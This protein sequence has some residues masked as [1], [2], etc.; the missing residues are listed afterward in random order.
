MKKSIFY[1]LLVNFAI[2]SFSLV[3]AS[4]KMPKGII[5]IE[6]ENTKSNLGEWKLRT[7]NDSNFVKRAGNNKHIEFTAGTI[8]GGPATSPLEYT[9]SVPTTGT[10]RLMIVCNKRLEG[11]S[12]DKCN[13]GWVK[14]AGNFES[15]NE[16]PVA[17]LKKNEKF[18]GGAAN[19]WGWGDL[20]DWQGHIKR[21]ALYNLKSGESYT[22]IMSGRSIRW[23]V[24]KI[25]LFD[26]LKFKMEDAKK[27]ILPSKSMI[28]ENKW[29][30]SVKDFVPAYYDQGN[31]AFAINTIAQPT[32]K[33]AAANQ[34]YKGNP[35]TYTLNF[36]SLLEMDGECSYKVIIDGKQV[37]SF[38]NPRIHGT[39]TKEYTPHLVKVENI[40]LKKGSVIEV[41]FLSNSNKLV[42]E[43]DAFGFARARWQDIELIKD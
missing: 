26:T 2:S 40:K 12:G 42:P 10:Y 17:D 16:I 43:K 22:F 34:I 15:G 1:L 3:Y 8:N 27:I 28:A 6:A 32:N 31:K 39:Q 33:W 23:N 36:R 9:F 35:G 5:V 30:L 4:K 19:G 18:F 11:A 41:Q 20:L 14:M 7:P 21:P 37:L 13:D 24:D 25:V 29:N 38:T